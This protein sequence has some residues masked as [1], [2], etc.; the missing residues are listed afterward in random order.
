MAS[1]A[2]QS[3]NQITSLHNRGENVMTLTPYQLSSLY[4]KS[5]EL[6]RN[7]DGLQPPE[8][9]D[10]LLKY[11][12]LK[13]QAET[14]HRALPLIALSYSSHDSSSHDGSLVQDIRQQLQ[15]YLET[16]TWSPQLWKDQTFN[17][18]DIALL[19]VHEIF[20]NID[21]STID[22]DTRS[23]ALNRFFRSEMRRG[24]GIFPT[25]DN[26]AKMMVDVASPSPTSKVLDPACG[27]GTFLIEVTRHWHHISQKGSIHRIW[28]IDK[29]PRML[30]LSELNLS[31]S[32][33]INYKRT[34]AD[35][36]YESPATL[37][38]GVKEGFDLILT[39]PPFGVV[40]DHNRH[41]MTQFLTMP[42]QC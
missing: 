4:Q 5:H 2:W 39:N 31:I 16:T 26:V 14:T 33:N 41:D 38:S 3:Q 20:E 10:E 24:L 8:A 11:M 29:S 13:E 28:G 12:F 17:L 18:S 7:V 15:R 1:G 25:P 30:L 19:A 22:I 40:I 6:M 42:E 21:F 35:S 37:F 34:Q 23:A 9:F 27:T 32:R 36:L